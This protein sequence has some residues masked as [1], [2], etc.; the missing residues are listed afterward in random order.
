MKTDFENIRDG[1][2]IYL[3][4]KEDNPL[5]L[6]P[7]RC[8]YQSGYYYAVIPFGNEASPDYYHGDV[9]MY[10]EGYEYTQ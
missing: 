1:S 2:E 6:K 5:T 9:W 10:N 7:H 4:P 8:I 3:F